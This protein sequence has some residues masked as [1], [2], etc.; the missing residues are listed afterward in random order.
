MATPLSIDLRQRVVDAIELEG[1][2]RR[3]A[4]ARFTQRPTR[5]SNIDADALGLP[6]SFGGAFA[7]LAP[8]PP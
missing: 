2:S 4:A 5:F 3:A 8:Q 7:C 1:M 6:R